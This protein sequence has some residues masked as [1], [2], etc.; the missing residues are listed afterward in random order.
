M[1]LS[2]PRFSFKVDL[3]SRYICIEKKYTWVIGQHYVSNVLYY[4]ITPIQ[5]VLWGLEIFFTDRQHRCIFFDTDTIFKVH[6]LPLSPRYEVVMQKN[7]WSL[8]HIKLVGRSLKPFIELYLRGKPRYFKIKWV[9]C[10]WH[11]YLSSCNN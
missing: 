9:L 1:S 4:S 2:Y 11:N 6:T 10:L 3:Y 5:D 7:L 8:L